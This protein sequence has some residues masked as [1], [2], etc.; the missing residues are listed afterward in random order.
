MNLSKYTP[1]YNSNQEKITKRDQTKCCK[2]KK[3]PIE[4]EDNLQMFENSSKQMLYKLVSRIYVGI[5]QLCKNKRYISVYE[6]E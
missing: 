4:Y 1:L 6:P 3:Q 2:T 5:K